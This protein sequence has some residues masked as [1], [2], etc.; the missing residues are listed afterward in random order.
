MTLPRSILV[1]C[2]TRVSRLRPNSKEREKTLIRL[3]CWIN[4]W[5]ICYVTSC[6]TRNPTL[7]RRMCRVT[8][9][10]IPTS[11]AVSMP[12]KKPTILQSADESWVSVHEIRMKNMG[13]SSCEQSDST[14]H[15][16][17]VDDLSLYLQSISLVKPKRLHSVL[18]SAKNKV[19]F[20]EFAN[21][22]VEVCS[23]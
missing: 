4:D 7:G 2:S 14:N 8:A 22:C 18:S 13:T 5:R 9:R 23:H 21:D 12:L 6:S 11:S 15:Y 10:W 1:V 20:S 19:L 3:M 16:C 17:I